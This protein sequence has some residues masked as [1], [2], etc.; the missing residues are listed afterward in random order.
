[1]LAVAESLFKLD[2]ELIQKLYV[3]IGVVVHKLEEV[4]W[5]CL[6]P[7]DLLAYIKKVK[8]L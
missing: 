7:P 5:E 2:K 1:V 8:Q 3:F 4:L 6:N